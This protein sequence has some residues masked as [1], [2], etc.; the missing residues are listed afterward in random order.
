[1]SEL[2]HIIPRPGGRVVRTYQTPNERWEEVTKEIYGSAAE[3]KNIVVEHDPLWDRRLFSLQNA[4]DQVQFLRPRTETSRRPSFGF[5]SV[6]AA[7]MV[8]AD[9]G[10]VWF[11]IY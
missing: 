1:M 6:V 10:W 8:L 4:H 11:R 5:W 9:L 2:Q 3:P 7:L